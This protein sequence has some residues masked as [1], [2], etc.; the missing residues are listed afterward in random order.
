MPI[1][2]DVNSRKI[3][4]V[5]DGGQRTRGAFRIFFPTAFGGPICLGHSAHFGLGL[6]V[7]EET[8]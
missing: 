7:P 4:P 6:F 1:I 5:I 2:Y 8:R 3:E